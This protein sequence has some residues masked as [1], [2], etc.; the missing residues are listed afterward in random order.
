MEGK[1][2]GRFYTLFLVN[3]LL[4]VKV[5]TEDDDVGDDVQDSHT[6]KD[7]GVIEGNFLGYLHHSEDDDQIGAVQ[8][9]YQLVLVEER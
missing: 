6:H 8:E 7:T 3:L 2:G 5:D 9:N 4:E 1:E